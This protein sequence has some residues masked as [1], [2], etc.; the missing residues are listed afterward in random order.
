MDSDDP[1][2]FYTRTV[3]MFAGCLTEEERAAMRER[4][5]ANQTPVKLQMEIMGAYLDAKGRDGNG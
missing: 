2:G 1:G 4:F 3:C 5:R